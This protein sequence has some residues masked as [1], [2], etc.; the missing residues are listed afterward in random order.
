[1]FVIRLMTNKAAVMLPSKFNSCSLVEIGD[2]RDQVSQMLEECASG[3]ALMVY[4]NWI[5]WRKYLPTREDI[6]S[7]QDSTPMHSFKDGVIFGTIEADAP[8]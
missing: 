6:Q 4:F 3:Q 2:F 5:T 8:K 1:M 7:M